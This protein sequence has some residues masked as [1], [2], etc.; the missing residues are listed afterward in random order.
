MKQLIKQIPKSKVEHIK[1]LEVKTIPVPH[2]YCITPK[3]LTG[4]SMYLNNETIRDAEKHH[5]AVCDTCRYL[6]KHG[7]QIEILPVDEHRQE[8]TLFLEVPKGDLNAVLGLKE[9]LLK[10][11]PVLQELK[12]SGVAFKQV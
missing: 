9:Y 12:I 8:L 7:R 2:L 11:K 1:V 10:I 4:T 6:V 5:G 3:H